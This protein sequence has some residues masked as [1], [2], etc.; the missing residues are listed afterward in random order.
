[1][2]SEM[3]ELHRR[4]CEEVTARVNLITG[5]QWSLPTPCTEWD[6][7]ALVEHLVSGTRWV[8]PL[9]EGM[10]IAQVGDSLN[11]DLLGNDPA[12]A[13]REASEQATAACAAEGAMARAVHLS[14]GDSPAGDYIAERVADLV[15]H[16][17]DLAKATGTDDR[18]D[19]ELVESAR[20]TYA[21]VGDLWRQYGV[22]GA[23]VEIPEGSDAQAQ[24]LAESGRDPQWRPAVRA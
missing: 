13:W 2:H 8:V 6:V 23:R 11:G 12:G 21:R 22:L 14:S 1:M 18:L 15:L 24:L 4:A 9:V 19:P 16:A 3:H 5:S 10:T 17:W 7:R 20:T